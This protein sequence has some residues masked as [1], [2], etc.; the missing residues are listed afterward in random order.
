MKILHVVDTF[1]QRF[2]RDQVQIVKMCVK[3]GFDTTVV[4]STLDSDGHPKGRAYFRGWD[5][6]MR[7][8]LIVRPPSFRMKAPGFAPLAVHLPHIRLFGRYDIVHVYTIG[9][10]SFFESGLIRGATGSK[11]V[12]RAEFSPVWRD[13]VQKSHAW[14]TAVVNW[15][16]H[17][18]DAIYALSRE[19]Q[20]RLLGI[21]LGPDRVFHVPV[22]VD[23]ERLSSIRRVDSV[24]TIGYFGRLIQIKGAL[25]IVSALLKI[26][27][28]FPEV[29]IVFAGEP[30]EPGYSGRVLSRLR[31]CNNFRYEGTTS[32][33]SFFGSTDIVLIP[34]YRET[35]SVST[36]EAMACG[37]TVIASNISPLN[38]Y[39]T[40]GESGLLADND[41]DFYQYCRVVVQDGKLR[42]S[43]GVQAQ[44]AAAEYD[45]TRMFDKIREIYSRVMSARNL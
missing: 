43:I 16:R 11:V 24:L 37:K 15:L 35:G 1:E 10:Y 2:E 14:R 4:T 45:N 34:S 44:A 3:S 6:A 32:P 19:E 8:A 41:E 23:F 28:E 9:S 36:L 39:I 33:E 12:L 25:R 27:D 26:A 38:E 13:R 5:T 42:N 30:T 17:N 7:P 21:G 18:V 31:Q 22:S 20:Q 40:H 29:R